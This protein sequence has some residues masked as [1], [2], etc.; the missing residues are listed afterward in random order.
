MACVPV[1]G[2]WGSMND[3]VE[4]VCH[5]RYDTLGVLAVSRE[6]I[7]RQLESR[8]YA[9]LEVLYLQRKQCLT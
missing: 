8:S 2:I 1:W 3:S 9:K 6:I 7:S 5:L 4:S